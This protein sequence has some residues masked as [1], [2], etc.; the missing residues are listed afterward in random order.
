MGS[1]QAIRVIGNGFH[2]ILCGAVIGFAFLVWFV[3]RRN[4]LVPIWITNVACI[5]VFMHFSSDPRGAL[6]P[7]TQT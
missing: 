7:A 4:N 3:T 6:I 1:E 5:E 2:T